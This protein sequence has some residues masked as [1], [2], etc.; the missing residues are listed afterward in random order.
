[1]KQCKT[2]KKSFG[3]KQYFCNKT[4]QKLSWPSHKAVHCMM[5]FL[6][7]IDRCDNID[8][9]HTKCT[10]LQTYFH[11]DGGTPTSP[12][13][14][15]D[16]GCVDR[17]L[18]LLRNNT[19]Y[20]RRLGMPHVLVTLAN[21]V[22]PDHQRIPIVNRMLATTHGDVFNIL[23][24]FIVE[25]TNFFKKLID[26]I[27]DP[28]INQDQQTRDR[29]ILALYPVT[30][31]QPRLCCF[32]IIM[33]IILSATDALPPIR[34]S[35]ALRDALDTNLKICTLVFD[36][37]EKHWFNF[38]SHLFGLLQ[39]LLPKLPDQQHLDL[40][41]RWLPFSVSIL[42]KY[43]R[44]Q[45]HDTEENNISIAALEMIDSVTL[46]TPQLV[47]N[48]RQLFD[49][50]NVLRVL[51]NLS[52]KHE[53][54]LNFL[55]LTV[56]QHFIVHCLTQS[57]PDRRSTATYLIP[58]FR[59]AM[60]F[61]DSDNLSGPEKRMLLGSVINLFACHPYIRGS[62]DQTK[63]NG[64]VDYYTNALRRENWDLHDN[65]YREELLLL[66]FRLVDPD[67][68]Y[69][70]PRDV[71]ALTDIGGRTDTTPNLHQH[72]L[73]IISAQMDVYFSQ[74]NKSMTKALHSCLL[75]NGFAK[76][77]C[78]LLDRDDI[79]DI[80]QRTANIINLILGTF[81]M[82]KDP[83][84][85]RRL[86]HILKTHMTPKAERRL[87]QHNTIDFDPLARI[88]DYH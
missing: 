34:I 72:I 6:D 64:A 65:L 82:D 5:T 43:N 8:I 79:Q 4:F 1:M 38:R 18:M 7:S 62:L 75:D 44:M 58:W 48:C 35:N 54:S 83:I 57:D 73:T 86:Q 16:A 87:R 41:H 10:Q 33:H 42:E 53:Q 32:A 17:A 2:C 3:C 23:F 45:S 88:M 68:Y 49:K 71:E 28:T 26:E 12:F 37:R 81:T 84:Q 20:P 69:L 55:L 67:I 85:M 47:N 70:R 14:V 51:K 74:D 50:E 61:I 15:S 66:V 63:I 77:M 46:V 22:K 21:L 39:C 11:P 29:K 40:G 52:E 59:Y 24:D 31:F 25:E 78:L 30:L 27:L 56:V 19:A 80:I 13:A 36:K 60:T 9:I 76:Y